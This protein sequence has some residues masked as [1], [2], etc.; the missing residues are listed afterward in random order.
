[1]L[2][3]LDNASAAAS[4][5]A[6]LINR[7]QLAA[8]WRCTERTVIRRERAGMPFIRLGML[9]L[10]EPAKVR[11]WLLTHECRPEAPKVG[12]PRKQRAA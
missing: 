7:K 4:I 9:R 10:Y 5:T 12:R 8:E 2:N 3:D 1:M 6:G 11:A